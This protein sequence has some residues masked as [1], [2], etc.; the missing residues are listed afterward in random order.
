VLAIEVVLRA[1]LVDAD[2][3]REKFVSAARPL[4]MPAQDSGEAESAIFGCEEVIH[5]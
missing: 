2:A 4:E 3:A 1:A 5:F